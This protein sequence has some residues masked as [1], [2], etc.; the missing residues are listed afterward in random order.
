LFS[1]EELP[2]ETVCT[3]ARRIYRADLSNFGQSQ[4]TGGLSDLMTIERIE[5]DHT[6]GLPPI[7]A[8]EIL[9][10]LHSVPTPVEHLVQP[11]RVYLIANRLNCL[12][13]M[14]FEASVIP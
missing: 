8:E 2:L 14:N 9:H 4:L 3:P 1:S 5:T 10:K 11:Q 7:K 12:S 6:F 13:S